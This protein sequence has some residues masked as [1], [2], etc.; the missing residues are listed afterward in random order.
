MLG[1]GLLK[2]LGETARNFVGSYTRRGAGSHGPISRGASSTQG[3]TRATS[4]FSFSTT[5]PL[6]GCRCVACKICEKECRPQ[7]IYIVLDGDEKG[8]PQKH[9]RIFDIDISVC[10]SCQIVSKFDPFDAIK[11]DQVYE[12][13]RFDR[14]DDLLLKKTRPG[15]VQRLLSFDSPTEA[16]RSR[17]PF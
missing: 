10:M 17:R 2:G 3:E 12:L 11:M 13:S 6:R 1:K 14:F 7:C 9:P 4:L 5:I 16:T 8:K 15:Q